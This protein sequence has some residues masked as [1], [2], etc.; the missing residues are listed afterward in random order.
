M[1]L[2][3][4]LLVGCQAAGSTEKRP[5]ESLGILPDDLPLPPGF[6]LEEGGEESVLGPGE[7]NLKLVL[8]GPLSGEEV[9]HFFLDHLRLARW[10]PARSPKP[11]DRE[12]V[13]GK[14]GDEARVRIE[15]TAGKGCRVIVRVRSG[16]TAGDEQ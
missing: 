3:A 9:F 16:E 13:F 6:F 4:V 5:P 2:G 8:A 15:D 10:K 14:G 1:L 11:G 12:L 7:R